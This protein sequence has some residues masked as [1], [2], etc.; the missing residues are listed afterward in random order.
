MTLHDAYESISPWLFR[1]APIDGEIFSSYLARIAYANGLSPYRFFSFH[2]PGLPVWNRDIDRSASDKFVNDIA[3]RCNVSHEKILAMTLQSFED[4]FAGSEPAVQSSRLGISPWIN[5][6]GIFHRTRKGYGMQYCLRCLRQG[7]AFQKIWRLSFVTVC[8]IHHCT[9]SDCCPH[10]DAPVV[11]HRN[12]SFRPSCH[13]CGRLLTHAA[14]FSSDRDEAMNMR[15]TLQAMLLQ[16]IVNGQVKVLGHS[17]AP[18]DFF[19]GLS[20][21]LRAFKSRFRIYRRYPHTFSAAYVDFPTER[22]ELLRINNRVRQC[23]LI[24]ELLDRWP[25]RFLELAHSHKITQAAFKN[26]RS[27]PAWLGQVAANLP[28]VAKRFRKAPVSPIRKKLRSIHRHKR[29]AWR[30]E[31]ATLLLKAATFRL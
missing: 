12:D 5:A 31:R 18:S 7:N 24:A 6:A 9:L 10:C 27:M 1:P 22:I 8:A 30:E 25:N 17:V 23:L 11:F 3:L 13:C 15:S 20:I 14:A 26:E 28:E 29:L 19:T 2:F 4:V 16:A 21:L